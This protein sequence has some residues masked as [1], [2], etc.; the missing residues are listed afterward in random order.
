MDINTI[1]N[2]YENNE[3]TCI[4]LNTKEIGPNSY[5]ITLLTQV[6]DHDYQVLVI[7]LTTIVKTD[8]DGFIIE[9]HSGVSVQGLQGLDKVVFN[10]E[11]YKE[12]L[13]TDFGKRVFYEGK[14]GYKRLYLKIFPQLALYNV[15]NSTN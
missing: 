7:A 12:L 2:K 1:K 13:T 6:S 9:K 10:C 8:R 4:S 14:D 5:S 3:F 15:L 11:L